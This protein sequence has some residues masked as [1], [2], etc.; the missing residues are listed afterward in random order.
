MNRMKLGPPQE[1]FLPNA[2]R[3]GG[4]Q[5]TVKAHT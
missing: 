4:T 2:L 3:A 1:H 5:S